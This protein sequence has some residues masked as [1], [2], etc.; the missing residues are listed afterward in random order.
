MVGAFVLSGMKVAGGE[1]LVACEP[2]EV[3][4]SVVVRHVD[5]SPIDDGWIE[6][7]EAELNAPALRVPEHLERAVRGRVHGVED[8]QT[9][10]LANS[11]LCA[12]YRSA[13]A[14]ETAHL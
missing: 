9:S 11:W 8:Q 14:G 2:V 1:G 6:L 7:V 5:L 3:H 12:T 4:A 10:A 13:P